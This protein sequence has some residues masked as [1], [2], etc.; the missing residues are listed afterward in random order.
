MR[1]QWRNTAREREGQLATGIRG[2]SVSGYTVIRPLSG[3]PIGIM[4]C[5]GLVRLV[6][7]QLWNADQ[8]MV[9]SGHSES[10]D[11]ASRGRYGLA[12]SSPSHQ[13][14][15]DLRHYSALK[16]LTDQRLYDRSL[17]PG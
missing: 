2:L 7:G 11:H 17:A 10:Q 13:L 14:L 1:G 12:S 8:A 9:Y 3:P 4:K 6:F 16:N 5:V 15:L